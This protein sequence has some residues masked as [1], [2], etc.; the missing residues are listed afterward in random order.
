MS[1]VE[2]FNKVTK[3]QV[4]V[5]VF[6]LSLACFIE[7]SNDFV[8]NLNPP[9]LTF[10]NILVDT[11]GFLI[12][13]LVIGLPVAKAFWNRL[14]SQVFLLPKINYGQALVLVT[15]IYWIGGI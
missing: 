15:C 9:S 5:S 7:A 1:D 10:N 11:V 4:A 12:V 13:G 6:F 2:A 8:A 14:L 3:K